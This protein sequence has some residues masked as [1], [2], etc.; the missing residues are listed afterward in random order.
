MTNRCKIHFLPFYS[1]SVVSSVGTKIT[2]KIGDYGAHSALNR[3]I[4]MPKKLRAS[5]IVQGVS[6]PGRSRV[7]RR[8]DSVMQMQTLSRK[9]PMKRSK[10]LTKDHNSDPEAQAGKKI[11]GA[12]FVTTKPHDSSHG[13]SP[14]PEIP[15]I[16]SARSD[17]TRKRKAANLDD[18]DVGSDEEYG[19]TA[20]SSSATLVQQKTSSD[21]RLARVPTKR[22]QISKRVSLVAIEAEVD[23]EAETLNKQADEVSFALQTPADEKISEGR[24]SVRSANVKTPIEAKAPILQNGQRSITTEM[25]NSISLGP[26]KK[27]GMEARASRLVSSNTPVG[28]AL[29]EPIIPQTKTSSE[30]R[31]SRMASRLGLSRI[32]SIKTTISRPKGPSS[33]PA[34]RRKPPRHIGPP[35]EIDEMDLFAR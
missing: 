19:M 33:N 16:R 23:E 14:S 12:R 17:N 26:S 20:S 7:A 6:P 27:V 31:S 35:S 13:R 9:T 11:A 29:S 24:R 30:K 25:E 1:S 2:H 5:T 10:V 15:K 8:D 3:I 21:E 32:S 28:D 22:T 18:M 4:P 34:G